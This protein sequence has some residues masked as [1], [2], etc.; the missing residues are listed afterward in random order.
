[1]V[2]LARGGERPKDW[3]VAVEIDGL[4]NLN[5]VSHDLYRSAQPSAM[6]MRNAR[7]I[8]IRTVLNLRVFHSDADELAGTGLM[9]ERISFKTWHP[10][11]EDMVKFLRIVTDPAKTPV[12]LHCQHGSDR[13]GTMS[14]VYRIVVQGWSKDDAVREMQAG[15]YGFHAIWQ[16]L[17]PWI[18]R[19]DVAALR[20]AAGLD[21]A[22]RRE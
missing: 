19:L 3:A 16:N 10:E 7:R 14:A 20:R 11:T 6:G 5:K 22:G 9:G 1:M 2:P 13:T 17:P 4:P 8:G 12:L 18:E 21:A 15:G